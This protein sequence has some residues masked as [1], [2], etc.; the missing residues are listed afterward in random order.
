MGSGMDV[1]PQDDVPMAT[2]EHKNFKYMFVGL[3]LFLL[4]IVVVL[5]ILCC[6]CSYVLRYTSFHVELPHKNNFGQERDMG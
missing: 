2:H 1:L 3:F 4:C 5:C 6:C